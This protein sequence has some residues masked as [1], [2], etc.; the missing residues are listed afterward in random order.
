MS[1]IQKARNFT[2]LLKI[3]K[4]SSPYEFATLF[5]GDGFLAR[6][7]SVRRFKLLK[8]IDERLQGVL[9]PGERVIF[10][11]TGTTMSI[12]EQFF[13]GLVAYYL[14][15]RAII[16]TTERILLLQVDSRNRPQDLLSQISYVEISALSST[17]QGICRI[18]LRNGKKLKFL[19][20]PRSDRKF[21]HKFLGELLQ[22]NAGSGGSS[23]QAL[24]HLC[25]R[26]Y[27]VVPGHP[28]QCP[29]CLQ[30]FKSARLA[31]ILSF[32]FPGI[33]DF[34]LGHRKIAV[35]EMIGGAF[36]WLMLVLVPIIDGG[37]VDL[38][39]GQMMAL[40]EVY[41]ITAGLMIAGVHGLDA[42]MTHFFAR[43]G[44]YPA[45]KLQ[46]NLSNGYDRS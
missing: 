44:H 5:P 18:L 22:A 26:C 27:K 8:K 31:A 37:L 43:K 45:G 20:V 9:L 32:V 30:K 3:E 16:F 34:Y 38:E 21:L 42:A 41:W 19:K 33:G 46:P 24:Q 1:T 17:W 4:T 7:R 29:A 15:K 11:T 23:A 25:P 13:V 35:L 14:N 10:I 12:M 40:D 28:A 36:L 2:E 39:T 6:R